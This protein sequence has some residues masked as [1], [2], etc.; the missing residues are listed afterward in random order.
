MTKDVVSVTPQASV[1][2][3]HKI[4]SSHFFT[5]LPV[6][7]GENRLVG[8]LTEYDLL[9]QGSTIVGVLSESS[10]DKE[11]YEQFRGALERLRETKISEI[12]NTDPIVFNEESTAQEIV[13]AFVEHHRVNPIPVV[14]KDRKVVGIVSRY[15]ALVLFYVSPQDKN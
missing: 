15:D 8:I 12:M 4:L 2:E 11:A 5:G 9:A 10:E 3:A 1:L 14:D 13:R 6:V 7:D